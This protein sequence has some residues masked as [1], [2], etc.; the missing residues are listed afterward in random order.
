[1]RSWL[2][3]ALV[4]AGCT[5]G[6]GKLVG[7]PE[8]IEN[9]ITGPEISVTAL[10]D[11]AKPPVALAPKPA[12]ISPKK[13]QTANP[14]AADP[15]NTPDVS[16]PKAVVAEVEVPEVLAPEIAACRKQGGDWIS[17]S[18]EGGKAC[19]QRTKDSGKSCR[20]KGD[21]EGDC[22]AKSNSCAPITPLFGCNDILQENG[23]M[24][25]LCI[26]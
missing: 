14:K 7:K 12:A 22:L 9:P 20:K 21:C 23:S 24:V 16:A 18:S 26:D 10:D 17:I 15:V 8:A 5:F 2:I 3:L 6:G 11:A 25:T 1:M 19:V 4:L 13:P